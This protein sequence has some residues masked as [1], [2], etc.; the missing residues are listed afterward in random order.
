MY[1]K[2]IG[3]LFGGA[4]GLFYYKLQSCLNGSWP[5]TAKPHRTGIYG[6]IPVFMTRSSFLITGAFV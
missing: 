3:S 4:L 6:T 2:I 1:T 5:I